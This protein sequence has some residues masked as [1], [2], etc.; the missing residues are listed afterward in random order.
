MNL[1]DTQKAIIKILFIEAEKS[2]SALAKQLSLSNAGLTL[3]IKPLLDEKLII[4]SGKAES[5][6][7]GRKELNLKLNKDYGYFFGI[8]IRKHNYYIDMMDFEGN[9]VFVSGLTYIQSI[10]NIIKTYQDKIL[11]FGITLRGNPNEDDF[12]KRHGEL[13]TML[14]TFKKDIYL[15][16][17][18]DALAEIHALYH[19]DHKN[20]LLIKYG[21]G[22]GSSVFIEGKSLGHQSELG[23]T[24][25]QNKTLENTISYQEILKKEVEEEEGTK[26][27]LENKESLEN[28]LHPLAF[29]LC[30]ADALLSLQHIILSGALLSLDETKKQ[31]E[32]KLK[33]INPQFNIDK[34]EIYQDYPILNTKKS[35]LI[36]LINFFR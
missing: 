26:L 34:L 31:L 17:N 3:A 7:L 24:Y 6:R 20:F 18:V 9:L 11:A 15:E 36:A 13:S 8:D 28:I 21:P 10:E 22:V 35:C 23:H 2:R 1:T 14:E 12:K 29:S 33:E 27:I 30:N 32:A 16:N 19:K 4:E 25:Y 5:K